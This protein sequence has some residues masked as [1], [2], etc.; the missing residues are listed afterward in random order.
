MAVGH[1]AT[2]DTQLS[3]YNIPKVSSCIF[4]NA[5]P[6]NIKIKKAAL[7]NRE[8]LC[9]GHNSVRESVEFPQ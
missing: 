4:L 8:Y 7:F 1:R 5:G 6:A 3:G 2:E 9:A